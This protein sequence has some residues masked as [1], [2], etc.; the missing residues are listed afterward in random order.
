MPNLKF[1]YLLEKA[2]SEW[3]KSLEL[4][5]KDATSDLCRY[6]VEDLG[7]LA[8]S[9]VSKYINHDQEVI[10]ANLHW[11]INIA[12]HS[13]AKYSTKLDISNLRSEAIQICFELNLKKVSVIG[14]SGWPKNAHAIVEEYFRQN[15]R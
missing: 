7:M 8:E 6:A 11:S 10:Y 5:L 13:L 12:I 2:L 4:R 14:E 15:P 9:I 3:P 1:P